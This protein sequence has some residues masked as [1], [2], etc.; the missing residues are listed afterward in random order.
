MKDLFTMVI[1]IATIG[2]FG[3]GSASSE[4]TY[5]VGHSDGYAVGYNTTCKI[6]ATLIYGH[7]DSAEYS[8]GYAAGMSAGTIA[9]HNS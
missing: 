2:L 1:I 6:R 5:D 3:C 4:K 7:W 8:E 9:C